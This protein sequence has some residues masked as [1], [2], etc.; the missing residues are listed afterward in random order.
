M[1]EKKTAGGFEDNLKELENIVKALE[2]GDVSLNDMLALFEKGIKL[3]KSCNETLNNAEQ[4][5]TML[6]KGMNGEMNE[7]PFGA[8]E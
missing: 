6:V 3:T 5:I 1:T 2:D 4:K 7:Q 8:A